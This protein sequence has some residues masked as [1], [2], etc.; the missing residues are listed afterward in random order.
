VNAVQ[1]AG[2]LP[3][4]SVAIFGGGPIGLI[5][6]GLFRAAGAGRIAVIEPVAARRGIAAALGADLC[7]DP[8]ETDVTERVRAAT[9]G[10]GADVVVDA[11]GN[12][13]AAAL[14]AVRRAGRVL[15]FGMNETASVPIRQYDITRNELTIVG[16]FVGTHVFP[17]AIR[18]LEAGLV[19]WR[20]MLTH[21]L[22]LD[23]LPRGVELLRS[24]EAVK[25]VVHLAGD[26]PDAP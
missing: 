19:D 24:G 17:K 8:L 9:D 22:P 3:G 20:P 16:T 12:Q 5:F 7:V 1:R 11:V 2:L 6:A 21:V 26:R 15:L 23:E 10:V 14:G 25:V 4:E 18:I 13:L